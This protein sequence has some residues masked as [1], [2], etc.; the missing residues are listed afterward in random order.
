MKKINVLITAA[1]RRV[2][3]VR[4][5]RNAVEKYGRGRVITTDINPLSPA[6]YF[7]HKHHIVPLTTDRYYIP[8]IESICD[9]E[10]VNL[11]IPTID[12]ELPIF[13]RARDRF[14]QMGIAVAVSSEKTSLTCNDKYET[15]LF[16]ENNGIQTART[17]LA[18]DVRFESVRYP[19][20]VK[21][22]FGRGS[23]NVFMVHNETQLRLFLDY[24]PDPIVQNHLAGT[25]FTVDV[26]CDFQGQVLSIVPRERLVIRAGVSDKG[27][28]RNNPDVIAFARDVTEKLQITGPANIQCKW[29][30]RNVS[31]IEVNPRFSGGIPLTIA[32]GGDFAAWLVQIAAGV[33]LKPQIGKFQDALTMMSF[34]ESIF[35]T[36]AELKRTNT[37]KPRML[38]KSRAAYVN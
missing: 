16:C 37:E 22:R 29:D 11:V 20:Y 19:V 21:P 32:S 6:L 25:E 30:G 15:Y 23:V 9:I 13:G 33:D 34:E 31:L 28:T 38:A 36:E 10:E 35:A 24:V 27:I 26:L 7:G 2:P 8:H 18:G 3:L 1:S 4:A 14:A 5:F 17:H 12:D